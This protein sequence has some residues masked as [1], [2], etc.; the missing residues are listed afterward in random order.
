MKLI[1]CASR[2]R[3]LVVGASRDKPARGATPDRIQGNKKRAPHFEG[4]KNHQNDCKKNV[5]FWSRIRS[6][7]MMAQRVASTATTPTVPE[8]P[9]SLIR[10]P[11]S[12]RRNRCTHGGAGRAAGPPP[13][14]GGPGA[15]AW[16]TPPPC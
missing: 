16:A 9:L 13:A 5:L 6:F 15:P 11:A 1:T 3:N 4:T 10:A 12:P 7:L 2:A 14:P 8:E